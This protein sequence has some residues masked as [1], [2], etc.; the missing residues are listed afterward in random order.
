MG[1]MNSPKGKRP[2]KPLALHS[3]KPSSPRGFRRVRSTP[4]SFELI[5]P[6]LRPI[7]SLP[8]DDSISEIMRNPDASWWCEREGIMPERRAF[9]STS[10]NPAPASSSL[11]TGSVKSLPKTALSHP[12]FAE[13]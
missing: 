6:F 7:E 4:V 5:L 1:P 8:L 9:R 3:R 13:R 10:A 12:L 11:P 2:H